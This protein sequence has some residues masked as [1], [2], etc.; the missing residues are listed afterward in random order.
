MTIE[1]MK[2]ALEALEAMQS[3]AAAERK[4]LRI[5]DEAIEALR[6]AIEQAEQEPVYVRD[7]ATGY[8]YTV[9]SQPKQEPVAWM[10]VNGE[11]KIEQTS[12]YMP[13]CE[14]WL[15]YDATRRLVPLYTVPPQREW[16]NAALR[17][18]EELSSVGPDG[19]YAMSSSEWLDWALA[20]NPKGKTSLPQ[21]EWIGLTDEEISAVDWKQ[22]ETLHD[23]AHA[24]EAKLKEKNNG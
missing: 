7:E 17:I 20:Q 5:C 3:Y 23:F 21:R 10:V 22:N 1:T 18:G 19:Y 12:H 8:M 4:G 24:I 15:K 16:Q 14:R 6:A 2:Q 13:E 9:L 11:G